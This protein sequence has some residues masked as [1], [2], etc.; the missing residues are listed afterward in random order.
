MVGFR[1]RKVRQHPTPCMFEILPRDDLPTCNVT[2]KPSRVLRL[3]CVFHINSK[4]PPSGTLLLTFDPHAARCTHLRGCQGVPWSPEDI[5]PT[6]DVHYNRYV[7]TTYDGEGQFVVPGPL[8]SRYSG[9]LSTL[10]LEGMRDGLED[11]EL[12]AMLDSLV[13][14]AVARKIEANAEAHLLQVPP[15]LLQGVSPDVVPVKRLFSEDPVS[16]RFQWLA[17]VQAIESLQ[18]KLQQ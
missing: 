11:L 1:T 16:L 15:A 8:D 13:H 6:M 17:I 14:Q 10:Q 2:V 12:L 5:T 7:N 4:I 18:Q 9:W 3:P